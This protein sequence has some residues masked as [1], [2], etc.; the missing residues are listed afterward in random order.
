MLGKNFMK[1][2]GLLEAA[3]MTSFTDTSIARMIKASSLTKA[4]FTCLNVFSKSFAA[5]ATSGEVT[6]IKSSQINVYTSLV[7]FEDSAVKPA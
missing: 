4:M 1:P 6:A 5:S 3:S 2:Y 7:N